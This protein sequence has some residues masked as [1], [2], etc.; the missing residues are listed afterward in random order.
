MVVLMLMY[1]YTLIHAYIHICRAWAIWLQW[2]IFTSRM[3]HWVS[4]EEACKRGTDRQSVHLMMMII[5]YIIYNGAGESDTYASTNLF[6]MAFVMHVQIGTMHPHVYIH[7]Y[8]NALIRT[9]IYI[10]TNSTL[11]VGCWLMDCKVFCSPWCGR[12]LMSISQ[13]TKSSLTGARKIRT[14]D[15]QMDR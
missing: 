12:L 4:L 1:I 9:D 14:C 13:R 11:N 2:A 5:T 8:W 7:S 3:V 6:E 10:Y 15:E